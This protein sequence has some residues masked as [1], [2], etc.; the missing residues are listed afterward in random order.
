MKFEPGRIVTTMGVKE[1]SDVNRGFAAHVEQSLRRHLAGDWGD[2][3][4]EDKAINE[5]ALRGNATLHSIYSNDG[6]PEIWIMTE[7]D[8]SR[9]TV[10]FPDEY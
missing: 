6:M 7:W 3:C 10:L 2:L 1:L 5:E 4:E 8:R 9:T